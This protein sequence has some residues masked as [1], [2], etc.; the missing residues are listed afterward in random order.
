VPLLATAALLLVA[1]LASLLMYRSYGGR[2]APVG[3]VRAHALL[4]KH[5]RTLKE[6]VEDEISGFEDVRSRREL[7][8]EEMRAIKRLKKVIDSA[9][10][11]LERGLLDEA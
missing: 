11:A 1:V 7:T 4:H 9:E 5:F 2:H 3:S 6:A 10:R 8:A